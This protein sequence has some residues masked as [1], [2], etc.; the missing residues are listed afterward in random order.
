MLSYL[1]SRR[2][3]A[4]LSIA[5]G[6]LMSLPAL[7]ADGTIKI[8]SLHDL[9]GG[10]NIYGIQQAQGLKLAVN[11]INSE[12]GVLGKQIEIVE[13]D[14]QSELSKYTQYANTLLLKDKVVAVFGGLTSASREAIRPIMHRA[15]IPYFYNSL[16]EGGVC[17]R[18][19]FITGASASQQLGVL[20]EWAAEN[21]GKKFYI[22]APDYNFGTIAAT[23]IHKYAKEMGGEV[24]GED[25]LPLSASDFG[26]TLRK[27]QQSQPDVV[28]ALPV[29]A[30]QTGFM[31]Q[32]AAA[33]LKEKI[34]IVSTNYGSGNQQVVVSPDAGEG[35]I[36]SQEYFHW[37][38]EPKNE[39]FK[40]IW[41][42][43]YGDKEPIISEAVDAW[44]A[45]HLWAMAVEKAGTTDAEP[46]ID[47][48]ESGLSFEGPNGNV[49]FQPGSHH[50]K[51]NIYIV[52]GNREHGFDVVKVFKSVAPTYEDEVCDLTKDKTISKQF[53]P[54]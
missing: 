14:T 46:V 45:A 3:I 4:A 25:F 51:Q 48:L 35:V 42:A 27:I 49:A 41:Q 50:L 24:V 2:K 1:C 6:L 15:K 54:E 43:A 7:A 22:M 5:A 9:T 47:A 52:R 17:D 29:G 11:D 18:Y 30:N 20:L 34:G 37:I 8:G 40:K 16:Y 53:V 13:Y 26:P 36:A 19:N 38:D 23:W 12:G 44:N 28:V 21:Y 39:E 10:L 32:F 33:G 31:E